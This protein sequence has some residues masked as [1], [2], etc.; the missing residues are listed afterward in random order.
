MGVSLGID[1]GAASCAAARAEGGRAEPCP[2]DGRVASP[3]AG[4]VA[5]T[6][7]LLADVAARAAGG[8]PD[9]VA[10]T[11][12]LA[13]GT[14]RACREEAAARV[15]ERPV[16]VPRPVAAA[17]HHTQGGPAPEGGLVL[18]VVHADATEVEVA[19]VRCSG[20]SLTVA[21]RAAA[22]AGLSHVTLDAA[23]GLVASLT[24]DPGPGVGAGVGGP[25]L[26]L[27]IGD[28]PLLDDLAAR[29]SAAGGPP[30]RV[31]PQPAWT[32]A[33]G[34]A[35]LAGSAEGRTAYGLAAAPAALGPGAAPHGPLATAPA[36]GAVGEHMGEVGGAVGEAMGGAGDA[37]GREAARLHGAAAPA[38]GPAGSAVGGA[39]GAGRR[40]RLP[41]RRPKRPVAAGLAVL[42]G[43]LVLGAATVV[44]G[45]TGGGGGGSAVE[46]D[47]DGSP[48]SSEGGTATT[49]GGTGG[50]G[51]AKP[52]PTDPAASTSTTP[53][54]TGATEPGTGPTG[55][56]GTGT[57][58]TT[59]APGDTTPGGPP[60][61][62]ATTTTAPPRDT[63]GPSITDLVS[64]PTAIDEGGSEFCTRSTVSQVSALVSDP[65]GVKSATAQWST[66]GATGSV[67][68][69]LRDGRWR[70]G[71]S[72]GP[73]RLLQYPGKQTV[74]WLV[75]ATDGAGNTATSGN[76]PSIT[77]HGC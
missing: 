4:D 1:L 12:P 43:V 47:G 72:P 66:S 32:A 65:S 44:A 26:V 70:G 49:S 64:S 67:A 3:D 24:A 77:L 17:A 36:G 23:A 40:L 54:S 69:T 14:A 53:T 74:T 71:V 20:A 9:A 21:G 35:L 60:L 57:P 38:G 41:V 50:T 16:L 15:F 48:S 46:T 55:P 5:G 76:G 7:A 31:D 22:G 45:G 61:P 59:A 58:A 33:L 75:T 6:A 11:Y 25:D 34:A 52:P 10:V 73:I 19:A 56:G 29:V 42:A 62:G 37:L 39:V 18:V 63:A 51:E 8:A 30:A 13:E 68:L 28:S 27:V 2:L